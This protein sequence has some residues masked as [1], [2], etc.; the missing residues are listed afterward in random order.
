MPC[1]TS[2]QDACWDH[3]TLRVAYQFLDHIG[4]ACEQTKVVIVPGQLGLVDVQFIHLQ[5]ALWRA[6]RVT[7]MRVR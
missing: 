5:I 6:D 7:G 2:W 4:V 3:H 1:V